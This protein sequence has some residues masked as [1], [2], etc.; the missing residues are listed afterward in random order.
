MIEIAPVLADLVRDWIHECPELHDI[1]IHKG[2]EDVSIIKGRWTYGLIHDKKVEI[3]STKTIKAFD[4]HDPSFFQ[5]LR[6]ELVNLIADCEDRDALHIRAVWNCYA[7]CWM[8]P[9]YAQPTYV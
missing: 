7:R 2:Y 9:Q 8:W 3:G 4:A 1:V 6:C 5:K